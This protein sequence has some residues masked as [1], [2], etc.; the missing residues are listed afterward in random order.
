MECL[1]RVESRSSLEGVKNEEAWDELDRK[2]V[3][4]LLEARHD[5]DELMIDDGA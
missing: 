1:D 4:W 5:E 2:A 3:E